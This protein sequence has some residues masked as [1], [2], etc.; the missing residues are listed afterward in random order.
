[1]P[2]MPPVTPSLS[3][4]VGFVVTPRMIPIFRYFSISFKLPAV[5]KDRHQFLLQNNR[6]FAVTPIFLL[7]FA[8]FLSYSLL[9]YKHHLT[10]SHFIST[11]LIRGSETIKCQ[12]TAWKASEC[13]VTVAAFTV[14]MMTQASAT[15]PV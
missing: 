7:A 6:L 13:A 1:M 14:G 11:T 10:D 4:M 12:I 15:L 8:S 5:Q 2:F 9:L 3:R